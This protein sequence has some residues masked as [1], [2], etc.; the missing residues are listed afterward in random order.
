LSVEDGEP[1]LLSLDDLWKRTKEARVQE[2]QRWNETQKNRLPYLPSNPFLL[3]LLIENPELLTPSFEESR[4]L[5][6]AK[7]GPVAV[8][9]HTLHEEIRDP[10]SQE[11]VPG[12]LVLN[13]S[14]LA[15]IQ[16]LEDVCVPGL[17]VNGERSCSLKK[18][19]NNPR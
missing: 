16:E 8:V 2:N 3:V 1:Q 11:E 14:V 17:E 9:L 12:P 18:Q 15:E 13:S 19:T 4:G 10:Q 7:E 5:S 6:R